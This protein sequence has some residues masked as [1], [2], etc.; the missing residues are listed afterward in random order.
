MPTTLKLMLAA[1][2]TLIA[3]ALLFAAPHSST[4]IAIGF[5]DAPE[6]NVDVRL[7]VVRGIF[8]PHTVYRLYDDANG[9]VHGEAVH[10]LRLTPNDASYA[11]R[12]NRR[13]RR[14]MRSYCAKPRV[15]DGVMSCSELFDYEWLDVSLADL[16][17]DEFRVLPNSVDRGDCAGLT[18]DADTV[19]I[20]IRW[21]DEYYELA[22]AEPGFCCKEPACAFLNNAKQ[23]LTNGLHSNEWQPN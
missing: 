6:A 21:P 12:Q 10:W 13:N 4:G 7:W 18:E 22:L 14:L 2:L 16:Q 19:R 23:I 8:V 11:K 17:L 20:E 3:P 1:C 5:P 9:T 15:F